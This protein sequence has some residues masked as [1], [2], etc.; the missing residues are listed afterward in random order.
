MWQEL[1]LCSLSAEQSQVLRFPGTASGLLKWPRPLKRS[2]CTNFASW[3]R[4]D[5][6]LGRNSGPGMCKKQDRQTKPRLGVTSPRRML[7]TYVSAE[8]FDVHLLIYEMSEEV[9]SVPDEG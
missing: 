6:P 7:G 2:P 8:V 1:Q 9:S 3:H 4:K 5:V